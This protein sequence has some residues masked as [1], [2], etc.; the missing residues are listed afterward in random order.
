M[1]AGRNPLADKRFPGCRALERDGDA[2]MTVLTWELDAGTQ[3]AGDQTLPVEGK[4]S[5]EG[6]SPGR[7]PSLHARRM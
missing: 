4:Y 6:S 1:A 3:V 7:Q 5:S 2:F